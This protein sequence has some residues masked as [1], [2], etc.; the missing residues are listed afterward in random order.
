MIN[1][2]IRLFRVLT[3]TLLLTLFSSVG[4]AALDACSLVTS[5]GVTPN[6]PPSTAATLKMGVASNFYSPAIDVSQQFI[7]EPTH[8][9]D[10]VLV[11]H[12]ASGALEEEITQGN[13]YNYS[14]FFSANLYF[15]EEVSE[16]VYGGGSPFLYTRGI[17]VLFSTNLSV[18]DMYN[19]STN[20]IIIGP[21]HVQSFAYA[22]PLT[23]PYGE[24]TVNILQEFLDQYD[25]I[26]NIATE[27]DNI[28]LTYDA[29]LSG[30]KDAGIVSKAQICPHLS[31]ANFVEFP[32]DYD[33][34]QYGVLVKVGG[35]VPTIASDY[36]DFV[37]TKTIQ[38]RLVTNWCYRDTSGAKSCTG[39][40]TVHPAEKTTTKSTTKK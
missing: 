4:Y 31:T 40:A 8:T 22:N 1:N 33:V 17:P 29:I 21:G 14:L 26:M 23:A 2:Q 3:L 32:S 9:S 24:A 19:S 20:K 27:Y 11:C 15:A 28:G 36:K 30:T 5:S 6:V 25:P 34:F 35:T 39:K 16:S 38:D 12:N 37:L 10:T 13:T 18:A 7:L